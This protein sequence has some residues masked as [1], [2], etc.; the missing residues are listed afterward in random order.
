MSLYRRSIAIVYEALLVVRSQAAMSFVTIVIIA[1]MCST[2]LLTA[3]KAAGAE[4]AVIGT[5]DS[6]GTKTIL[7]RADPGAGISPRV[8]G[9]IARLEGIDWFGAVGPAND[10]SNVSIRGGTKVPTRLAWGD[11]WQRLLP[12]G[13]LAL[14]GS[15]FA[16]SEALTQLGMSEKT[17]GVETETGS[18]FS[19]VNSVAVPSFLKFLEPL[20]FVPRDLNNVESGQEI[21]VLVVVASRPGS[22]GAVESAIRPLIE[23]AAPAKIHISTSAGLAALR[24]IVQSQLGGFGRNL[25]SAVLVITGFLVAIVQYG[26][27]MLRRKDFGRRRALGATRSLIVLLLLIQTALLSSVGII[28]GSSFAI[29]ALVATKDPLPTFDFIAAIGILALATG[30]IGSLAP[31]FIA[32]RRDPLK[33]LRVP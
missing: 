26:F 15:A 6:A 13:S 8:L 32:A 7:V 30:I 4:N 18:S 27:V 3:G 21:S 11:D 5:L 31:A 10:A 1:A 9:D 14:P 17:G 16:S 33:E 28:V 20:A 22:V 12:R 2:I 25:V 23:G 19:V 24:N 29:S